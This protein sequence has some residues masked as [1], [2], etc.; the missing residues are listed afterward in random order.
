MYYEDVEYSLRA[1]SKGIHIVY[2]PSSV[3]YHKVGKSSGGET[4]AF[5]IYYTNRNR[6]YLIQEYHLGIVCIV[7]T[8]CTRMLRVLTAGIRKSND[9]IIIEAY[10][11]FRNHKKGRKDTL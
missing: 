11:D 1:V 6:F 2:I 7:Y 3:I 10:R 9:R 4:S 8:F 5:S